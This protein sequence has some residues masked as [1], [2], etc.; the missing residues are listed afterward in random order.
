MV[1]LKPASTIAAIS[2]LVKTSPANAADQ[3]PAQKPK[4][5]SQERILV[6]CCFSVGSGRAIKN[7]KL[8]IKNLGL[9]IEIALREFDN[10]TPQFLIFNL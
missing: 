9:I 1:S 4:V 6:S 8:K 3:P 5:I 2:A 10:Q 7:Y